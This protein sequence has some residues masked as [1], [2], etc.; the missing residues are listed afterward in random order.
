MATAPQRFSPTMRL[1]AL[2]ALLLPCVACDQATKV[3][4]VQHLKGADV[5]SVV[6]GFFRL[7]YAENPGA[8]LSLGRSL[9]EGIRQGVL[10]GVVA[11]LLSGLTFVLLRKK[12]APVTFA[13]LGLL[14]A[15]GVGNLIDRVGRDG[16]RVVDF[17]LLQVGPLR[18]GVFNVADVQIVA[19]A[20]LLLAAGWF[21]RD[22]FQTK[23]K[24]ASS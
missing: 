5:V 3:L 1:L 20:L 19:A 21:S 13:A 10:I 12:L 16:G 18:T 7:T 2:L 22:P 4:A 17:A 9:P 15:G 14:L 6:D 8:F 11:L 23:T 24:T